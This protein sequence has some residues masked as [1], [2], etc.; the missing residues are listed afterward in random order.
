MRV[1]PA[2]TIPSLDNW[3]RPDVDD[4]EGEHKTGSGYFFAMN[5]ATTQEVAHSLN[6]DN[7]H[8]SQ[9]EYAT[10]LLA[11]HQ[12]FAESQMERR[13][14]IDLYAAA[15]DEDTHSHTVSLTA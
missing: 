1:R 7:Y 9:A 2:T 6:R 4:D 15:P 14:H 12:T 11:G 13:Q 10:Q 5:A 3:R 8:G